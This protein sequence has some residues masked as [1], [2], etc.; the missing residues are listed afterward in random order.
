LI[1]LIITII[2]R[3]KNAPHLLLFRVDRFPSR[4]LLSKPT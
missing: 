4:A 1:M 2:H 3:R